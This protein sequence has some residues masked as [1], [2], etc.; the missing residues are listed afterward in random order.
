MRT[1][2]QAVHDQF[3]PRAAAYLNSAVHAQGPDLIHAQELINA[4]PGPLDS[5]LD[6]GCGAGHLSFALAPAFRRVVAVDPSSGMLTTVAHAAAARRLLQLEVQQGSA[7]SLPFADSTFEVVASRFSAHHWRFLESGVRQMCRV[8]R[9][10]GHLLMI[11]TMGHEDALVDTHLQAIELL[12][13]P[14]HVRNRSVSQWRRLLEEAGL[15]E[16]QQAQWP[17]RLEF[18]SWAERMRAPPARASLIREL[19]LGAAREVHDA[20]SL[21]ADGSFR[22]QVGSFWARK[23]A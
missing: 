17:L 8:L 20:L 19:Q 15:L 2:D 13:D 3:D 7:E 9:P 22:I 5:L 6:V 11:D 16:V 1:H 10:G 21:E 4:L 23:G 14:S 12:R 18:T